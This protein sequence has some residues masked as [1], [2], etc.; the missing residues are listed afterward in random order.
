MAIGQAFDNDGPWPL[1]L[2]G[3]AGVGKSY[4][5]ALLYQR[6]PLHAFWYRLEEFVADVM[7]CRREGAVSKS[8]NGGAVFSRTEFKLW[9]YAANSRA[10]WC[11]DDFGTRKLTPAGFEVVFRLIDL[12]QKSPTIITT[13]LKP[14][15]IEGM[16]DARIAS[17][18][19]GGTVVEVTGEDRRKG[20]RVRA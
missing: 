14:E 4:A 11:L 15:A 20:V 5:M 17:R 12:R 19:L 8:I 18:I 9:E 1:V 3:A 6:T 7:T 2:W 10:V 13:N 16:Y